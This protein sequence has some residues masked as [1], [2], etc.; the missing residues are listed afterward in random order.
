[1]TK[2]ERLTNAYDYL[3][4]LTCKSDKIVDIYE[5]DEMALYR[6]III[7]KNHVVYK[8]TFSPNNNFF[9]IAVMD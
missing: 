4:K 6:A 2:F 5:I 8:Y 3:K 1:M 7:S 9:E